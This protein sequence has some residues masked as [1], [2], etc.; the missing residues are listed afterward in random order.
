MAATT[1]HYRL[2]EVGHLSLAAATA[3]GRGGFSHPDTDLTTCPRCWDSDAYQIAHHLHR[4]VV[5]ALA[6]PK[7]DHPCLTPPQRRST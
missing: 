2:K 1:V 5:E 4:D 7:E 6:Y 3:C